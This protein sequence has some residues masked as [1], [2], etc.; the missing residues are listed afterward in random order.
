MDEQGEM[1]AWDILDWL[2]E[3]VVGWIILVIAVALLIVVPV[4]FYL[5]SKAE[6]FSLRKDSWSCTSSHQESSTTYVQSGSIMVPVT[7]Y[8]TV[9]DQWTAK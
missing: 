6:R 4:G 5:D 8:S 7:G 2:G 9:C 3:H 1:M